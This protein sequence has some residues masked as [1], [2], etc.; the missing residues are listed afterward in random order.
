[1]CKS[2]GW[3]DAACTLYDNN[4]LLL[5]LYIQPERPL[6]VFGGT[7]K[8]TSELDHPNLRETKKNYLI[9]YYFV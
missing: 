8:K 1:M 4:Y 3:H 7:V 6:F 9:L 5:C 2:M